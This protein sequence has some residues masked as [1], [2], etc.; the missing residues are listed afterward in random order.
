MSEP[1]PVR[2]GD[3]ARWC[4]R[5]AG[6]ADPRAARLLTAIAAECEAMIPQTDV[7]SLQSRSPHRRRSR[8]VS[9][10]PRFHASSDFRGAEATSSL[11]GEAGE[12]QFRPRD[13]GGVLW[14]VLVSTSGRSIVA[15]GVMGANAEAEKSPGD[16]DGCLVR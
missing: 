16:I 15:E 5:E 2:L 7:L 8:A 9:A 10:G 1:D 11:I 6:A 14:S 4:R 3:H 12:P 13:E